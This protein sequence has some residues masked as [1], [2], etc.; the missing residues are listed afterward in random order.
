MAIHAIDYL[1][2]LTLSR[3][4]KA[5][6]GVVVALVL[7]EIGIALF[8]PQQEAMQKDLIER[9]AEL[10]FRMRPNY[11]GVL[12]NTDIPLETNS[13]GLR[14]REFGPK[15]AGTLRVYAIGDSMVFGHGIPAEDA[16][17]RFLEQILGER[18][19][20]PVEVVNGG[21]PGYGTVQVAEF[22]ARTV[23]TVQPDLVT[24]SITVFND[25]EDNVKFGKQLYRW[26]RDPSLLQRLR[27]WL[28]HNSQVYRIFRRYRASVSGRDMMEIHSV[29]PSGNVQR[30]IELTAESV[31]R[32]ADEAAKR[33]IGFAVV[34]NP[35]HKQASAR[36][37]AETLRSYN[38]DGSAFDYEAP[39]RQLVAAVRA[40]NVPV[41]D[42]LK[43]FRARPN[44]NYY[45]SEHWKAPGHRLVATEI[46]DFLAAVRLVGPEAQGRAD[47]AGTA[48]VD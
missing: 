47:A 48:R 46:A 8:L 40:Q 22:F 27:T 41:L 12:V 32:I 14:D 28:R 19:G 24:L 43:T 17:P 21:V 23:D 44:E 31:R 3:L 35:A 42:L 45:F 34:V 25:L 5:L 10:G 39:S 38:L 1:R 20:H 13:W 30:G 4:A 6:Y 2:F 33:G 7:A 9:D 18:L 26:Q 29:R 15:A 36:E 16:F 37:W 11:R